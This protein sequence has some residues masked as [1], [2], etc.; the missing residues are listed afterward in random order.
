[1]ERDAHGLCYQRRRE[2]SILSSYILLIRLFEAPGTAFEMHGVELVVRSG[3]GAGRAF[4][5]QGRKA[6]LLAGA[7]NG[8]TRRRLRRFRPQIIDFVERRIPSV[9]GWHRSLLEFAPVLR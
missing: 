4:R 5:M 2:V 6:P 8:G 3:D 7:K 1:M 9:V